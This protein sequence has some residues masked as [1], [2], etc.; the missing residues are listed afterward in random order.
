MMGRVLVTLP[1]IILAAGIGLATGAGIGSIRAA[2]LQARITH[3]E[4]V[5]ASGGISEEVL[6]EMERRLDALDEIQDGGSQRILSIVARTE[7]LEARVAE[8]FGYRVYDTQSLREA[9][10]PIAA[11][12]GVVTRARRTRDNHLFLDLDG[13]A[14]QVVWWGCPYQLDDLG[15]Q[16]GVG[17]VAV[18]E[19]DEYNGRPQ[20]IV[21]SMEDL[22]VG[23]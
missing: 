13:G 8:Q 20:I 18:G 9:T 1:I 4:A 3:L 19:P 21:D 14:A 16:D 7:V 2:A 11:V 5:L 17:I 15:I 6:A 23:R 22:I 12:A 10:G